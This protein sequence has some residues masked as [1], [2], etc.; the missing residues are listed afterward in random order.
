ME[1]EG[2]KWKFTFRIIFW[3]LMA[4]AIIS[5]IM[6][7]F[8]SSP[9]DDALVVFILGLIFYLYGRI[10]RLEGR[11]ELLPKGE[12]VREIMRDELEKLKEER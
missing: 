5:L 4:G 6:R 11:V 8:R 3:V 10:A 2:I 9:Y 7:H 1:E 12:E